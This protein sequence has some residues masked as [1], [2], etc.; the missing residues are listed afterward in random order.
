MMRRTLVSGDARAWV[1]ALHELDNGKRRRLA[2][3]NSAL[4][5]IITAQD[6]ERESRD[7]VRERLPRRQ[8]PRLTR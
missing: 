3:Q 5:N 2:E 7:A 8:F 6:S 4:D 1:R